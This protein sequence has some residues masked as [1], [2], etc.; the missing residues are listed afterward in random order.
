MT[1]H[2]LTILGVA[3]LL[4]ACEQTEEDEA[5]SRPD[6]TI[7]CESGAGAELVGYP[8]AGGCFEGA[9]AETIACRD[10]QWNVVAAESAYPECTERPDGHQFFIRWA[11]GALP[12][13]W[14]RCD[15]LP[16]CRNL[17]CAHPVLNSD[18]AVEDY[19]EQI[20]G[21]TN[22]CPGAPCT[23]DADCLT[24]QRCDPGHPPATSCFYYDW[25]AACRATGTE[26]ATCVPESP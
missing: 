2:A 14:K 16:D 6:A 21:C 23:T 1:R 24:G 5:G 15:R 26:G 19:C 20:G 17:R 10:S 9:L 11:W 12:P 22:G 8:I 4:V 25:D 18:C 13:G 3:L 7:V